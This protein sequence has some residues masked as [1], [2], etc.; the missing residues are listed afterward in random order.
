MSAALVIVSVG[1]AEVR[2]NMISREAAARIAVCF[3]A[4]DEQSVNLVVVVVVV[5]GC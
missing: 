4:I 2:W 3:T 5:G 1:S